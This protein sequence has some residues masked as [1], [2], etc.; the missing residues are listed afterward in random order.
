MKKLRLNLDELAV[1]SFQTT[2]HERDGGTVHGYDLFAWSDT[3][4]CPSATT[5]RTG[6]L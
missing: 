5:T 3:S 1:A 4:V 2:P 6:P